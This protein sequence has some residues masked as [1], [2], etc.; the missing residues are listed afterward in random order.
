MP[1]SWNGCSVTQLPTVP[2]QSASVE[3]SLFAFAV[4]VGAQTPKEAS[5]WHVPAMQSASR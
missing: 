5:T 2:S 4:L 1:F 3:H